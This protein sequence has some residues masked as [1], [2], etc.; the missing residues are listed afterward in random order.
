MPLTDS[1]FDV[2]DIVR[3]NAVSGSFALRGPSGTLV[4][5]TP[6]GKLKIDTSGSLLDVAIS[7]AINLAQATVSG[8]V[9]IS[10]I[11]GSIVASEA[12]IP[13]DLSLIVQ[14]F[15]KFSGSS[16]LR[17]DGSIVPKEF[18][19]TASVDSD[20]E[21]TEL[22]F[23]FTGGDI[24]LNGESFG[25]GTTL[26]GEGVKITLTTSGVQVPLGQLNINEDF[27]TFPTRGALIF[28]TGG[29]KD[30]ISVGYALL[31]KI[32]LFSGSND[33]VSIVIND[34][35]SSGARQINYFKCA[36]YGIRSL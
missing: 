6:D 11:A 4:D 8:T 14:D 24:T 27:L 26:A 32:K 2:E 15:C 19:F 20:I 9:A 12:I 28:D 33:K 30:V 22:R 18:V 35:L 25:R 17:I 16:D 34:D 31:G 23:V 13:D 36:V 7:G 10:Q 1:Q 21:L 29:T 3:V 5:V